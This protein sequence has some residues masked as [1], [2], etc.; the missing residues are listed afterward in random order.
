MDWMTLVSAVVTAIAGSSVLT[1]WI[2]SRFAK[3]KSA[4]DAKRVEADASA[5]LVDA[6]LRWQTTLTSRIAELEKIIADQNVKIAQLEAKVG[7]KCSHLSFQSSVD[8]GS[9]SP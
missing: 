3:K 1:V 6:M 2:Q 4:A 5:V 9:T 7:T 8:T